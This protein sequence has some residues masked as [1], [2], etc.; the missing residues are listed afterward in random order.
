MTIQAARGC[1]AVAVVLSHAGTLLGSSGYLGHA[2]LHDVFRAGHA[3]VDFFFVL[4]GFI[5]CT[6]H[7]RD[8]GCPSAL[9]AYCRK[10]LT[11]IYPAY[12]LGL[13][14]LLALTAMHL[15][16]AIGL[17]L[18]QVA[19]W[20]LLLSVALLP[21][22]Q[23]P[24][25]GIA[26]TLQHE[27][28]FY[29]LFG[30]AIASRRVGLAAFGLWLAIVLAATLFLPQGRL[31]WAPANLLCD[32]VGSSYHLQF[33]LGGGIAWLVEREGVPFPRT[34]CTAGGAG[35]LLAA[36]LENHGAIAYLGLA[37]QA[38]F[39]TAA[40]CVLAGAAAAERRGRLHAGPRALF[41]GAASYAIYLVHVPI[42]AAVCP[43]LAASGLI[44]ALP[45]WVL[46][47]VLAATGIAGGVAMHVLLERPILGMLR[48]A[49]SPLGACVPHAS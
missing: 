10:R 46:M 11:R 43:L 26:S 42:M 2:P 13:A 47:A 7:H 20:P 24:L 17:T 25:L 1:A 28:L 3:G 8:I 15:T 38:L 40:A 6:V 34:L 33:L 9:A 5:I 36:A 19:A 49:Y 48:R 45:G 27:M 4:S 29:L 44:G 41:L 23:A 39:G 14:V 21:Q 30:L 12:W 18:G 16:A 35:L 32:F 22:H 31:P 37:S